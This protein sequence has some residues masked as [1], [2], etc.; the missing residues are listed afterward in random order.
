MHIWQICTWYMARGITML[1]TLLDCMK[2]VSPSLFPWE[3]HVHKLASA[4]TWHW[5]FQL[6]ARTEWPV[7]VLWNS[8]WERGGYTATLPRRSSIYWEL[9]ATP[10]YS[11]FS[12]TANCIFTI[13]WVYG[14]CSRLTISFANSRTNWRTIFFK[15]RR[16]LLYA[17]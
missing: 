6:S 10:M 3:S 8:I 1:E 16:G 11:E 7:V 15:H 5:Q 4:V 9:K 17:W 2:S 14:R 13:F 12:M